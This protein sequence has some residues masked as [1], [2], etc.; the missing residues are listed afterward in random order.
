MY[1]SLTGAMRAVGTVEHD[2]YVEVKSRLSR[3]LGE[4]LDL[5]PPAIGSWACL[6]N[7]ARIP[8]VMTR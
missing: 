6:K 8:T 1:R 2:G 7:G 3:V 5:G 4:G